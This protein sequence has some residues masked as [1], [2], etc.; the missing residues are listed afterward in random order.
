MTSA[1]LPDTSRSLWV[2]TAE[3]PPFEPLHGDVEVDVAVVGGGIVGVATAHR[4]KAAGRRVAVVEAARLLEGTTGHTTAKLTAGHGLIYTHLERHF[5]REKARRYAEANEW[6]IAEVE[7]LAAELG[8]DCDFERKANVVYTE[9]ERDIDQLREEASAARRASLSASFTENLDLPYPIAAA[10]TVDNEAQYHPRKLLVPMAQA[11]PGSGSHVFEGSR[12]TAIDEGRRCE[13]RTEAGLVRAGHVVVATT[14]PILFRG[15]HFGRAFPKRHYAIAGPAE[16]M[17]AHMYIST[18]S[19]PHSIRTV[20]V[21]GERQ[22]LV[23]GESHPVGAEHDTGNR[24]ERLAAWALERFGLRDVRYRWSAQDW[25][26]AD[27]VPLIGPISWLSRRTLVATG[28]GG[29]GMAPGIAASRLLSDLTLGNDNAWA[30]LYSP[31]RAKLA[32]LPK[33]TAENTKVGIHWTRDRIPR[34]ARSV[35]DLRPGEGGVVRSG[36]QRVAAYR[37]PGGAVHAVSPRCTHLGCEVAWNA[38]ERSWDCACHGS[39]FGVDG[40]VLNAPATSP[41]KKL[42]T[43][44][45]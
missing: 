8:I 6:G 3:G 20:L 39:R 38:A 35:A 2:D 28:F 11:L 13:V 45:R 4:L 40:E 21:D 33:L 27:K 17:P 31:R 7:R 19:H 9:D 37:D 42:D 12:V 10:V 5:G 29:W 44:E 14:M 36:G 26:S 32:A 43:G 1:P 30:S 41:L 15:L 23:L 16:R 18:E 34:P 22:L 24:F 25:Y